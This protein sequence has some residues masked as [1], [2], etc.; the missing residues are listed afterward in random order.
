MSFDAILDDYEKRRDH[1]L[2]MGGPE[3]VAKIKA[4]GSLNARERIDYL[5]DSGTFIESGLFAT[6]FI[7]QAQSST[8]TDGKVCGYGRIDGREA[9][10]VSH[11]LS[12]KGASSSLTN[13]KKM[14]HMRETA[15][16]NGMPL[17]LLNESS[18]ARIPD[19][20]GAVGTGALG[21]DNEQFVRRREVPYA[22]A[23]LGPAYGTAC[24]FTQLSDFVAMR[25]G[26]VL[27]VSS[28]KVTEI[29]IKEKV[30]PE[31]LGGWKMQSE[32]TGKVDYA[33]D[34][35]EEAIDL[36][37]KF[38]SY[39]PSHHNQRPPVAAV[40]SGSGDAART[41]FDIVPAERQ[42]VYDMRKVVAALSDTDSVFEIKP[43]FA[44]G[45]TTAFARMNGSTVGFVCSNPLFKAGALDPDAC[46]KVTSFLVLCDSFNIP[47][48]F[49]TDTPGFLIGLAGEVKKAPG[50]IMNFMTAM[51][52]CSVPKISIVMRKSYGQAYLN[53]AGTRNADEM[54]AWPSADIGFMDPNVAVNVVHGVTY[55]QDPEK[56]TQLLDEV[57]QESSAYDLASIFSSQFVIDPRETRDVIIRL[58]EVHS[59]ERTG[60]ISKHQLCNWPTTY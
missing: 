8:P 29:A 23:V 10:V 13:V 7:P 41:I 53:M 58:L 31:E 6:S 52:L 20:M 25:K 40:P 17:V 5:F 36:I 24:W 37:K 21:Q 16:K 54:L 55:E 47:L 57:S 46:D 4:R 50:K 45:A 28:P 34:T 9:A 56:F 39:L 44:R 1:A 19:T 27:A 12:V 49:L 15:I 22:A 38:L 42:K 35:D 51:Q 26:S 18:G 14:R 3:R 30:D 59:R 2:G 60:G 43:R 33:T 11:D 32:V 48:V